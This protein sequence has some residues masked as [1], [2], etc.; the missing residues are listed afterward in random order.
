MTLLEKLTNI[1]G[2]ALP[3]KELLRDI[4]LNICA[5]CHYGER[6]GY[7]VY[8]ATDEDAYGP[9]QNV[10]GGTNI[11]RYLTTT[12]NPV[13]IDQV[14]ISIPFLG[15][16]PITIQILINGTALFT[17]PIVMSGWS[18]AGPGTAKFTLADF[19]VFWHSNPI[20]D[21]SRIDVRTTYVDTVFN[22]SSGLN[23]PAPHTGLRI[24]M[25][26]RWL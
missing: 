18:A 14:R 2:L 23:D 12:L 4:I 26:G 8:T 22:P 19:A 21:G 3:L 24:R 13:Y 20:P 15:P 10:T 1:T 9:E 6:P 11:L 7:P 25:E 16:N 17:A 5:Y